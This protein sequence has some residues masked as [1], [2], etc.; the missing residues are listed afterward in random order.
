[1][2]I[3]QIDEKGHI[4]IS[5]LWYMLIASMISGLVPLVL[6]G[7]NALEATKDI[8]RTALTTAQAAG[9]KVLEDSGKDLNKR[10]I[11]SLSARSRLV[12]KLIS[13]LMADRV[14]DILNAALLPRI[15]Q[16]YSGFF[17]KL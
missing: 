9:N 12:A 5:I 1:M 8:S 15:A 3:Q 7:Y 10:K 11:E 16:A 14:R 4:R 17:S 13:V 6:I 2:N